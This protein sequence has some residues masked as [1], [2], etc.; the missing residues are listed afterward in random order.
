M[1]KALLGRVTFSVGVSVLKPDDDIHLLLERADACLYAAKRNGSNRVI[2]ETDPEYAAEIQS[3]VTRSLM[4][5]S[6]SCASRTMRPR[7]RLQPSFATHANARS[8]GMR[9]SSLVLRSWISLQS[10]SF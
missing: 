8:S 6:A 9:T 7:F 5:R 2:C 10:F 1:A 3:Q 4:V